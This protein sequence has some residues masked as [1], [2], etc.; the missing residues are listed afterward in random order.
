MVQSVV[1]SADQIAK[2]A[3]RHGQGR[4]YGIYFD[5]DKAVGKPESEPNTQGNGEVPQGVR[6]AAKVFIVGHT[7]SQWCAPIATRS[8]R[9]S[10]R[11]AVVKALA[12]SHGI[13]AERMTPEALGPLA[14]VAANDAEA[15]ARR[16]GVS[17]WC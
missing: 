10:A 13:P 7:D 11:P 16:T 1:V 5:T 4:V 6:A 8:F 17:R 3:G 9:A 15:G 12:G 2:V 14:P